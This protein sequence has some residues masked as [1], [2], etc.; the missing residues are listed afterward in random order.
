MASPRI[1]SAARRLRLISL[2]CAMPLAGAALASGGP[3]VVGIA[4]ALRNEVAI[5]SG[6]VA[7]MRPAVLRERVALADRVQTGQRSQLQLMLLDRTT[8]TVGANAR[9][10]IDR[11]VYDPARGGNFDAS[12]AKGAFRFLSGRRASPG[13]S[14]IRT[15]I[16]VIGIRGT[17]ID[18]VVG[19]DAIAIAR[20]E[21]GISGASG[22]GKGVASDPETAS[23]I[24]LRGP[25]AATEAGLTVGAVSVEAGGQTVMLQGPMQAAFVPRPGAAPIG[26][27]TLSPAGLH[28]LEQL[29]EVPLAPA[30]RTAQTRSGA[31]KAAGT[32]LKVGIGVM[33]AV[34][35]TRGHGSGD[36]QTS[37]SSGTMQTQ[38]TQTTQTMQSGTMRT[39][40][41]QTQTIQ[42]QTMT[43]TMPTVQ[44]AIPDSQ[45]V[46]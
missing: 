45:Q 22:G 29:I 17:V 16:A 31:G 20:G 19:A 32:L 4:A 44:D 7:Q 9:L 8:F 35:S 15:P 14:S 25:G 18:G 13:S 11:F 39:E 41:I 30:T 6:G 36:S 1:L 24:V 28:R 2:A 33:G 38:T 5:S 43:T 34:M 26:P 46:K 37:Q 3:Q 21:R 12:V 42:T 27:F 10:T 40:T 23:L